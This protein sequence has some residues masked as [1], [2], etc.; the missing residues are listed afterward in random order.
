MKLCEAMESGKRSSGALTRA[1]ALNRMYTEKGAGDP[2]KK[3]AFC[4][5]HWHPGPKWRS[6]CK[7][8]STTCN[9]CGKRG[10][11]GKACRSK[12]SNNILEEATAPQPE[13]E[14]ENAAMGFLFKLDG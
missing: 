7:A 1:G 13:I 12:K 3:C 5:E 14:V 8:S 9:E 10:H 11:L 4:G 6:N 2:K